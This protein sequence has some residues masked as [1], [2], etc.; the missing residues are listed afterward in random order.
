MIRPGE[1]ESANKTLL[2]VAPG[3]NIVFAASAEGALE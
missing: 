3:P 1:L 2:I